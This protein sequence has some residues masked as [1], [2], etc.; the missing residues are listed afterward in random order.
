LKNKVPEE[1]C[2]PP[3]NLRDTTKNRMPPFHPKPTLLTKQQKLSEIT[4]PF[5]T[6]LFDTQKNGEGYFSIPN[7]SV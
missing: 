2:P 4:F 5:K 3:S 6:Q 7:T 1:A